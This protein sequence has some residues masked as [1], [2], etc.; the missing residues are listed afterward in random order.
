MHACCCIHVIFNDAYVLT[1]D[2]SHNRIKY[3]INYNP[4]GVATAYGLDGQVSIPGKGKRF[5]F[6]FFTASMPVMGPTQPPIQW[7]LGFLSPKL[8]RPGH[9]DDH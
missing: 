2:D 3:C 8:K 4:V 9:K 7:V 6:F 5:F 1:Y